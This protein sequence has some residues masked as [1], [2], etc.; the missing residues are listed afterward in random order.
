LR[1]VA[2]GPSK[3]AL[4]LLLE[5]LRPWMAM[6]FDVLLNI[7]VMMAVTSYMISLSSRLLP[8]SY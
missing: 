4:E 8:S 1:S 6:F 3:S 2:N 5:L 7:K